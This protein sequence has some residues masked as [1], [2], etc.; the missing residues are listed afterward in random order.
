MN[1][2]ST[3]CELPLLVSTDMNQSTSRSCKKRS[4][5]LV[6]L[7][8]ISDIQH[9]LLWDTLAN[10]CIPGAPLGVCQLQHKSISTVRFTTVFLEPRY[11]HTLGILWFYD[12]SFHK[13]EPSIL[14]LP[15]HLIFT[16]NQCQFA[17][18][19][20]GRKLSSDWT[21][22][23]GRR[24]FLMG[25]PSMHLLWFHKHS[26][27]R[28]LAYTYHLPRVRTRVARLAVKSG[29]NHTGDL[30]WIQ[31]RVVV[32]QLL[33]LEL[34]L[35]THLPLHFFEGGDSLISGF[36]TKDLDLDF[37]PNGLPTSLPFTCEWR[38]I[39][40]DFAAIHFW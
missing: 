39:G 9:A 25:F 40:E 6:L 17:F 32:F 13:S 8:T 38:K 5:C 35:G 34:P 3:H 31:L 2:T 18:L 22:S 11:V 23:G 20:G 33:G 30:T 29:L 19:G 28:E 12:S 4:Q 7:F 14:F 27:T 1:Q 24:G 21:V 26:D 36:G 15:T 10:T 16:L 37:E